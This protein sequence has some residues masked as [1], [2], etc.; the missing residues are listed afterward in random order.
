MKRST[1]SNFGLKAALSFSVGLTALVAASGLSAMA[2]EDGEEDAKRLN[3]VT[4]TATKRE[5]TL[6][7][8]PVAVSV[9]DESVIEKAE[10]LDLN[11]LQSVVPSLGFRTFQNSANANFTI[12][13]FGNGAN[14]IGIEPSVGIFIDGVYRSRAAASI[15]DLPN[16]ERVEVLRGPQS[17]L[18]G[19]NASAGVVSVVTSKPQYELGGNIE[20]SFGNFNLRR[21]KGYVTGGLTDNLAFS[22]GGSINQR[23]GV[24]ENLVDGAELNT[25]DRWNI[26]GELLLEPTDR[27]EWRL[28]VDAD[29][30]DEVCCIAS[31]LVEGPTASIVR[32]IGGNVDNATPFERGIFVNGTPNNTL[33]NQGISLQGDI[34]FDGFTITTITAYRETDVV[35]NYDIDFTSANLA[36]L[37]EAQQLETFSQELRVTSNGEG[38]FDWMVGGYYFNE[39]AAVQNELLYGSDFRNFIDLGAAFAGAAPADI[40]GIIGAFQAGVLPSPLGGLEAGLGIPS[41]TLAGAGQ[42]NIENFTQDDEAISIFGTLDWYL[43][44]RLTATVGLNYTDTE[45]DATLNIQSLD[46]LSSLD[47]TQIGYA[48][49]VDGILGANGVDTSDPASIGA[50]IG[51]NPAIYQGIQQQALAIASNYDPS[52]P[53]ATQNPLAGL[54]PLQF[55]PPFVN[56]P[57]AVEDGTI[58][59]D[60][61]TYSLRLAYDLTENINVYGSYATGFKSNSFNISRDSRPFAADFTPSINAA[62]QAV[63]TVVDPFTGQVLRTAPSSPLQD[64]GLAQPN[65]I[66]GTRFAEPEEAKVFEI[67]LKGA[68]DNFALNVALFEQTIENFQSNIF[69]GTGFTLDNAA[70][71]SATGLELDAS[72]SPTA[73]L[74]LSFAGTFLDPVYDEFIDFNGNDLSGTNVSGVSDVIT[75]TSVLYEFGVLETS[76]DG[77]FRADWQYEADTDFG[78]GG[79]TAPINAAL[80]DLYDREVNNVNA[81][82]GF[83]SASGLGITLWGRNVFDHEY[84]TTAFPGVAQAGTWTGY[85]SQP[86]TYG[87]TVRKVF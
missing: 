49:V 67:G 56:F 78:D 24:A 80:E 29:E 40:P 34:E 77:F 31:N 73:N 39:S 43:T 60:D 2:Q 18:F 32:L 55:Q 38:N 75:S 12:R 45:K 19:K 28:I 85:P 42:G 33:E 25:R 65:L 66:T 21:A 52:T 59:A 61:L 4:I 86:R 14:N 83:T 51:G 13:G 41:G 27:Q 35:N 20:A 36:T 30:I 16:I 76:W 37:D 1:R 68:W 70:E 53:A 10:I 63:G 44:D 72:W 23:D 8:V 69:N 58:T 11:D 48:L 64:A 6:Q 62:N 57:N 5:Q 7:D 46:V 71:Q 22:L 3:T 74:T 17:T 82:L 79:I 26:R 15:G 84:I 47:L 50:F 54:Q 87:V 81:S 9:I